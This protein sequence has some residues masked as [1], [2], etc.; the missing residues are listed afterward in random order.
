MIIVII[1]MILRLF[2]CQVKPPCGLN[3]P[4]LPPGGQREKIISSEIR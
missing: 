3:S 2:A 4:P 1:A